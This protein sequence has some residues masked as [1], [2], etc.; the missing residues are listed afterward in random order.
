MQRQQPSLA[1]FGTA[2]S[3]CRGFEIDI[4]KFKVT[5][6]ADAQPRDTQE[7]EQTV[8]DRGAQLSAFIAVWHGERGAE[9]AAFRHP[10]TG[11]VAPASAGM[12]IGLAP[13]SVC[14]D[15]SRCGSA[16]IL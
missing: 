14:V 13:E 2:D 15:R 4:A 16:Q 3:Q 7:P 12:A 11:R 6:F 5:G 1:E 8:E 10:N 9:E